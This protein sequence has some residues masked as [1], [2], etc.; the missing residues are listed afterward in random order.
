[1]AEII[2]ALWLRSIT[3]GNR[4]GATPEEL[5]LD[6]TRDKAIDDNAFSIELNTVV[7]NSFNIHKENRRLVF[8]T[9][10][11]PRAKL[12]AY[13]RNDKHFID[14]SDQEH[15]AKQ[16]EYVIGDK[17]PQCRVIALLPSWR[18][19]PW[20]HVKETDRPEAWQ[21][22]R[23]P[24]LVLPEPPETLDRPLEEILGV[25]LKEH[26]RQRRNTIRFLLPKP[27]AGETFA[28]RDLLIN[29][30]ADMTARKWGEEEKSKSASKGEYSKL[31]QE[32][33]R[34][35]RHTLRERFNRFVVLERWSYQNPTQTTLTM[36]RLTQHGEKIP[37]DIEEIIISGG[38]FD[39]IVFNEF[40]LE[41]ARKNASL[42]A[43]LRD[44]REPRPNG[45]FCIPY[46][47]ETN[48]KER[49]ANLCAQGDIALELGGSETLQVTSQTSSD[50]K[51]T[52]SKRFIS[53]LSPYTGR[54]LEKVIL[55]LPETMP[56]TGGAVHEPPSTLFSPSQNGTLFQQ[57]E[58]TKGAETS[59]PHPFKTG[60]NSN[61]L[62]TLAPSPA[63]KQTQLSL[64]PYESP[65]TSPLNL[66]GELERWGI[67]ATTPL[68]EITLKI[69]EANGA[70]IKELLTKLPDGM[71]FALHL[72]K[73]TL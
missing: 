50:D 28:D 66:V 36:K 4:V 15:L 43:L 11:N 55:K 45:Q 72:K 5:Q 33:E 69:T 39:F 23:L 73:E 65:A 19:D 71:R 27:D 67:S 32:F 70:Q 52:E 40:V 1:M 26:V 9:E 53:K 61:T 49:V 44:L 3:E 8:R 16:I 25:W 68:T 10:E 57:G 41:L 64:T 18:T 47:G 38:V 54:S 56:V 58:E 22:D 60:E 59:T 7:E 48:I 24:I 34:A 42:S 46:L 30:R 17:A 51:N 6:I 2:A 21:D 35:I 14:H 20:S 29:V 12:L 63:P 31:Q 62:N 37:T 13:A